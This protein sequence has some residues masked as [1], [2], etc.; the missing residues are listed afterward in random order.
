MN[1]HHFV[2]KVQELIDDEVQKAVVLLSAVAHSEAAAQAA[3]ADALA[4][5]QA[6]AA[7]TLAAA[8]AEAAEAVATAQAAAAAAAA[9]QPFNIVNIVDFL[10]RNKEARKIICRRFFAEWAK[11]PRVGPKISFFRFISIFFSSKHYSKWD[12]NL[13]NNFEIFF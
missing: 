5:A 9:A 3:T 11:T 10:N 6:E 8:Q 12:S 2:P 1:G 4:A 13:I 7:E